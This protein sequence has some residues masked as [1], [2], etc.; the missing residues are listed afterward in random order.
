MDFS[1]RKSATKFLYVKTFS[2][3]VVRHSLPYLTVHKL[4]V[5]DVPSN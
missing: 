1:Q 4:L 5:G 3:T 2:G